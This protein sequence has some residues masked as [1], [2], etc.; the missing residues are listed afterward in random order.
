MY[1]CSGKN[2]CPA[3]TDRCNGIDGHSHVWKGCQTRGFGFYL[4]D[5]PVLGTPYCTVALISPWGPGPSFM[6]PRP[7]LL[8]EGKM[9]RSSLKV[10]VVPTVVLSVRNL[11]SSKWRGIYF[12]GCID[13]NLVPAFFL[14]LNSWSRLSALITSIIYGQIT[15]PHTRAPYQALDIISSDASTTT[16]RFYSRGVNA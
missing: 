7:V 13:V 6:V 10:Q 5:Y 3:G 15:S 12:R 2:S 1:S 8:Q 9:P 11:G 16:F 14:N 4:Q